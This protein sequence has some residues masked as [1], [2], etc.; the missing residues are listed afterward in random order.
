MMNHFS[1]HDCQQ[2]FPE[3]MCDFL[4]QLIIEREKIKFTRLIE[5]SLSGF[6]K[7]INDLNFFFFFHRRYDV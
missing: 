6:A 4:A 5:Y 1:L 7:R 2:Q 3:M